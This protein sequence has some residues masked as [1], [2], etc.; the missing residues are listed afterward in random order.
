MYFQKCLFRRHL[1]EKHQPKIK[2]FKSICLK[3]SFCSKMCL[4]IYVQ[5]ASNFIVV[6]LKAINCRVVVQKAYNCRVVVLKAFALTL[7][8][9]MVQE[10]MFSLIL[11]VET[12]NYNTTSDFPD[13]KTPKPFFFKN[14]FLISLYFRKSTIF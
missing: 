11:K 12:G 9:Q 13:L 6:V 8:Y 7:F 3:T 5:K 14:V 1:F 10:Q 2:K 4:K